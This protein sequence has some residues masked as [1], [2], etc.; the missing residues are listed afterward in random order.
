MP[1]NKVTNWFK[2]LR[3]PFSRL[4]NKLNHQN[5]ALA[6]SAPDLQTGSPLRVNLD[7]RRAQSDIA[8]SE[9]DPADAGGL[10]GGGELVQ[11]DTGDTSTVP[12]DAKK[13]SSAMSK[14]TGKKEA[15]LQ[16][17]DKGLGLVKE[18]SSFIPVP[19]IGTVIGAVS[20]CIE[21]YLVSIKLLICVFGEPE[22][23]LS[24]AASI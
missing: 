19:G 21:A 9:Q 2:K 20:K 11:Q 10:Q 8:P 18:L 3:A 5:I 12:V 7:N 24:F 14:S 6:A 17:A 13:H 15:T 23:E 16:W 22:I 4:K 1:G